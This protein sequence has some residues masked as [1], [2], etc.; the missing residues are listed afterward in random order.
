M[1]LT[2]KNIHAALNWGSPNSK[3]MEIL[4]LKSPL[5]HGWLKDLIGKE[6]S[7]ADYEKLCAL[8]K[9]GRGWQ[10]KP[11]GIACSATHNFGRPRLEK[12]GVGTLAITDRFM[13]GES[14]SDLAEDYGVP[15]SEIEKSLRFELRLKGSTNSAR[16][17]VADL[18]H[19]SLDAIE[20]LDGPSPETFANE[21]FEKN[22]R[23]L[24]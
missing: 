13:A 9:K 6:M 19:Q 5:P 10:D 12:S 8:R 22:G 17:G 14:I 16:L 2:K 7:D 1:Q 20:Q 21:L 11:D 23:N 4:G 24:A 3:Q 15:M 18:P